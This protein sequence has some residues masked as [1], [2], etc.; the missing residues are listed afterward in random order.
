MKKTFSLSI[1]TPFEDVDIKVLIHTLEDGITIA[2][3]E[4]SPKSGE[5]TDAIDCAFEKAPTI[6]QK[7]TAFWCG[8]LVS[9]FLNQAAL[10]YGFPLT[11]GEVS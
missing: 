1:S 10:N 6:P 2:S 4:G 7:A 3:W 8:V 11:L 9:H 5:L